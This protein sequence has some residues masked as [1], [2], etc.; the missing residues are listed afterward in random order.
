[1]KNELKTIFTE[2]W[3]YLAVYT[4]CKLNIFDVIDENSKTI[5]EINNDLHF[6]MPSLRILLDA[7]SKEGFIQRNSDSYAI[8]EKGSF[9]QEKHADSLKYACMNWAEEHLTA[10][11][12]LDFSIITGKSSFEQIFGKPFFEY[13]NENPTKL[14][15]YHKAMFQYA[16][17][18]YK[19]L[20]NIIDFSDYKSVMDVGGGL[21]AAISQIK[22]KNPN[23]I[24]YLFDLKDVVKLCNLPEV[25]IISGDFFRNIPSV[26]DA[27]IL[28]R[29]LHD[30]P[31][32]KAELVLRNCNSA[33]PVGGALYLIEN[34]TDKTETDV[35]L[36]SLNM[37]AMCESYERTSREY[38][39]LS[40][41]AGFYFQ[42]EVKL[43]ELQTILIFNKQ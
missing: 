36:L 12:N 23:T 28:C 35:S 38:I 29:V 22:K 24:C 7:L 33:L 39:L 18:D 14:E 19:N 43:N 6:H 5:E 13:L 26:A 20:P 11:Q 34:S 1:M 25:Q 2:H 37:L 42:K 17:D 10:W 15:N 16:V 32:E 30:W 9:L 27:I 31:D 4:A 21:G 3:K 40:E 41:N 8:T